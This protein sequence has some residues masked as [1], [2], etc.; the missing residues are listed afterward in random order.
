[1]MLPATTVSLP[2]FFT[3]SRFL[4]LPCP[5]LCAMRL[6]LLF[7][8]G[9]LRLRSLS[10]KADAGD[11][12]AGQ[13]P[14]MSDGAVITFPAAIF[15]RDDL[16]VLALLKDFTRNGRAFDQWR[17]VRNLVAIA[18]NNTLAEKTSLAGFPFKEM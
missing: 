18:L 5:F 3:P 8:L 17:A 7:G 11:L 1:M 9:L 2:N 14:A 15:E 13:F 16:L 10:A 12:H 6:F 4:T